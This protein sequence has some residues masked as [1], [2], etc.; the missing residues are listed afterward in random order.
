MGYLQII[1]KFIAT[2]LWLLIC[3]NSLWA[4]TGETI[5]CSDVECL[6]CPERQLSNEEL[7][8]I[9]GHGLKAPL[10]D[11]IEE[12]ES[13]IILWDEAKDRILTIDISAGFGN[14]QRNTLSIVGR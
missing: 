3:V 10:P 8:G 2:I 7:N 9:T 12:G 1:K 14:S 5:E 4:M 6:L 11:G 13:R